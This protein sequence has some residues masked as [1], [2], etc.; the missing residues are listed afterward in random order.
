VRDRDSLEVGFVP[1]IRWL[2]N[3][4]M[5]YLGSILFP[6]TAC[7]RNTSVSLD[8]TEIMRGKYPNGQY[9]VLPCGVRDDKNFFEPTLEKRELGFINGI[10]ASYRGRIKL[11]TE[12]P[13]GLPGSKHWY[14]TAQSWRRTPTRVHSTSSPYSQ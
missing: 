4:I 7:K 9:G 12:H 3:V 6:F 2:Y 5:L 8:L 14:H 13:P 11:L 1:P 10:H